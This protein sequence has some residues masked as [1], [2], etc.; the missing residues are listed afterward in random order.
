MVSKVLS[1]VLAMLSLWCPW[2]LPGVLAGNCSQGVES[3]HQWSGL[4]LYK[5]GSYQCVTVR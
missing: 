3:S 4:Q 1:V 2:T 5:F